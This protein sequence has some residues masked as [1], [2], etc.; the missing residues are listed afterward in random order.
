MPKVQ[1]LFFASQNLRSFSIQVYGNFGGCIIS[2]P[3]FPQ[4]HNFQLTGSE[5]FPPLENLSLDGYRFGQ[6]EWPHWREK[7]HWPGLRSL[8]LGPQNCEQSLSLLNGQIFNLKVLKIE[9]YADEGYGDILPELDTFLKSFGTL[10][11]LTVKGYSISMDSTAW[12]PNLK[13]FCMH[14]IESPYQGDLR[15]TLGPMELYDLDINCPNL[16][17]LELDINRDGEWVSQEL[18]CLSMC[19]D[20]L[21]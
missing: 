20:L 16:E 10:E 4:I 6:D 21:A 19:T 13:H 12:H 8:S 11:S 9:K 18:I 5:T 2:R 15:R 3:Q 17:N 7:F 1:R 14:T